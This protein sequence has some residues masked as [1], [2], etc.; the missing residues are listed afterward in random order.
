MW[1]VLMPRYPSIPSPRNFQAASPCLRPSRIYSPLPLFFMKASSPPR[2]SNFF[3]ASS[4]V[5]SLTFGLDIAALQNGEISTQSQEEP[6]WC[7]IPCIRRLCWRCP[8]WCRWCCPWGWIEWGCCLWLCRLRCNLWLC[9]PW[10]RFSCGCGFGLVVE[11]YV[12]LTDQVD[13][14]AERSVDVLNERDHGGDVIAG[15]PSRGKPKRC[16]LRTSVE[17]TFWFRY[18]L[19]G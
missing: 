15:T 4:F 6:G 19:S 18:H 2:L 11:E 12:A 5:L 17:S 1:Y 10:Y 9:L 7:C 3:F 16:G 13:E 14:K 8:L